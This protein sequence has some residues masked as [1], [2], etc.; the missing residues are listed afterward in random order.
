MV[1]P[2]PQ[3]PKPAVHAP[4]HELQLA[5]TS[6]VR[7]RTAA[8]NRARHLTLPLLRRQHADRL[9]CI[10]RD[11]AAIDAAI[12]ALIAADRDS[13]ARPPSSA[14]FPASPRSAPPPSSPTCQRSEP[15]SPPPSPASPASP[16]SPASPENGRARP[17]S[18][19]GAATSAVP[20]TCPPSP[21]PASTPTS[22]PSTTASGR[23]ESRKARPHRRHAQAH[24]PRKPSRPPEPPLGAPLTSRK[25]SRFQGRMKTF[26]SRG[27]VAGARVRGQF[28]AG[29]V[30]SWAT[31]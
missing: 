4:L 18:P 3:A 7:A 21:P 31:R 15:S 12:A 10:R 28:P 5:R 8:R 16:R 20:S 9:R 11:L 19:A 22:R 17:R 27:R 26:G 2:P 23:R 24:P 1:E 14:A 13:P 29:A 6:L 25:L 30:A